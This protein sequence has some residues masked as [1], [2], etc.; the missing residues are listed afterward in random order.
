MG[1]MKYMISS[2]IAVAA[3]AWFTTFSIQ[4]LVL[5]L[6][7]GGRWIFEGQKQVVQIFTRGVRDEKNI[8]RV[9]I[10]ISESIR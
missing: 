2:F 9:D 8:E 7:L 1:E 6:I 3:S 10:R 5:S 4:F